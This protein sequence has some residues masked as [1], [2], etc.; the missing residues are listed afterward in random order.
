MEG[1]KNS[2]Y[3]IAMILYISVQFFSLMKL[4]FWLQPKFDMLEI[5]INVFAMIGIYLLG[6]FVIMVAFNIVFTFASDV[7]IG[8]I[9]KFLPE[10]RYAL[11]FTRIYSIAF[12]T[13]LIFY[14]LGA[15]RTWNSIFIYV[16]MVTIMMRAAYI[17]IFFTNEN[18][19]I[20][21][22]SADA[23]MSEKDYR[24]EIKL[25]IKQKKREI[26]ITNNIKR[27]VHELNKLGDDND[28]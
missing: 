15:G 1:F 28:D 4:S 23:N 5:E 20:K 9:T 22:L 25:A 16:V 19:L 8:Q 2:L 21:K 24:A 12:C 17:N 7:I 14:T 26:A 13:I 27:K 11:W 3:S 18:L 10:R 6:A